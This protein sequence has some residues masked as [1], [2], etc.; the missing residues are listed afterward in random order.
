[1]QPNR[2]DTRSGP[3]GWAWRMIGGL[4]LVGLSYSGI[5]L[6]QQLFRKFIASPAPTAVDTSSAAIAGWVAWLLFFGP[7]GLAGVILCLSA[8]GKFGARERLGA[9]WEEWMDRER[10]FGG[11]SQNSRGFRNEE[12]LHDGLERLG[13]EEVAQ[14]T[15]RG[16][17]TAMLLGLFTGALFVLLGVFGLIFARQPMAAR[18][19]ADFAAA[20]CVSILAGLVILWRTFRKENNAWLVPLKLFML[21]VLRLHSLSAQQRKTRRTEQDR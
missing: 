9:L 1:M 17:Q 8:L 10:P 20:S 19:S 11:E 15:K 18:L 12:A 13:D 16:H 21:R 4:A 14:L 5:A 7:I 2:E 3:R 6:C